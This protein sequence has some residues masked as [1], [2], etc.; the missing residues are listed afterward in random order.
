MTIQIVEII[1]RS[2]QGITQPFICRGD[3]GHVYFV[4]G[5]DA[6]RR[7]QI[8]E[9]IAGK[10][11]LQLGLP[12]APFEIVDVPA[13]LITSGIRDDLT[14]LGTGP[15]FGSRKL[16]GVELTVTHID[17]VP[18]E[19]QRDVLAFD[20]WIHN[21]DRGL[22]ALGGNPNLL[23][24]TEHEQLVVIDHNQAFDT[25]FSAAGFVDHHVFRGQWN[26]L[27]AN[28][29]RRNRYCERFLET[30]A[31]WPEICET[32]PLEWWFVDSEQTVRTD[33]DQGIAQQL[34]MRCQDVAFWNVS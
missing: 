7:S 22:G 24:D 23:W 20:W 30:M 17:H 28:W 2:V 9:W 8:C 4:K 26:A 31:K 6:G 32:I 19:T 3:D 27:A 34:L 10:L 14:A 13:A 25:E 29:V 15:A 21:A 5:R 18:E 33:F 12:I 16:G 11:A 1:D